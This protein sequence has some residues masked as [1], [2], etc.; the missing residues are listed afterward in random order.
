MLAFRNT[1]ITDLVHRQRD[2]LDRLKN[3]SRRK[4]ARPPIFSSAAVGSGCVGASSDSGMDLEDIPPSVT[5]LAPLRV[6]QLAFCNQRQLTAL[7][8]KLQKGD[9]F[10]MFEL[11]RAWYFFACQKLLDLQLVFYSHKYYTS[12]GIVFSMEQL[13]DTGNW[14]FEVGDI[15]ATWMQ[16]DWGREWLKGLLMHHVGSVHEKSSRVRR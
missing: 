16:S 9:K 6:E 14:D 5:P 1:R 13:R 7:G 11:Y 12:C 3:P 15:L 8:E 4:S 2:L 10:G